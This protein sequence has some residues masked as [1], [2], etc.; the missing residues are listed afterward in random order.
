MSGNP[1]QSLGPF[2]RSNGRRVPATGSHSPGV[3]MLMSG[4]G[5]GVANQQRALRLFRQSSDFVPHP[6]Y[7]D[8]NAGAEILAPLPEPTTGSPRPRERPEGLPPYLASL[9]GIPLLS[10]EQEAHLFRRMNYLKY[11]D[12]RLRAGLA[13]DNATERELDEIEWLQI[14]AVETKQQIIRA[15]LRLVVSIAK[16]YTNGSRDMY[17][18]ISDGNL[19]LIRAVEKFDFAR[20][21]KFSTYASWAIINRFAR[22]LPK[23]DAHRKRLR[24]GEDELIESIPDWKGGNVVEADEFR[25]NEEVGRL[26]DLLDERER[27]IITERYGI[28]GCEVRTLVQL[29]QELGVSKE[30]IRQIEKRAQNKLLTIARS[31]RFE[32]PAGQ[33]S[34]STPTACHGTRRRVAPEGAAVSLRL[35]RNS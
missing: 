12:A 20:G 27:R 13:P 5:A 30:R 15:N 28:G 14:E 8:T 17:E 4:A 19:A 10:R 34:T 29:G 26:I 18:L 24:T 7:D 1:T 31:Q 16:R 23:E 35:L 6:S 25:T 32:P 33:S 3:M 2:E 22:A 21:N 9:Y 11:L